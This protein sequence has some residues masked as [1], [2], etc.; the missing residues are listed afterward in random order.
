MQNH[1]TVY[2]CVLTVISRCSRPGWVYCWRE[3]CCT[4]IMRGGRRFICQSIKK[5]NCVNQSVKQSMENKSHVDNF[6]K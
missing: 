5:E 6:G 1:G 4:F 3:G 2:I